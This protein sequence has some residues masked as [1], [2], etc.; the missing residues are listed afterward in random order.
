MD[1]I[2]VFTIGHSNVPAEHILELLRQY[3]IEVLVDVRSMPYSRH[4]PQFNR[5]TFQ[6]FLEA[7]GIRYVYEGRDLGGRPDDPDCYDGNQV[8]YSRIAMK[9]WYQE[10]IERLIEMARHHRVAIMCSEEDPLHC[11]R[12]NLIAQTLLERG[13]AVW[14]IRGDGRIEES[15]LNVPQ[16]QQL[17]LL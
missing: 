2:T 3:G 11:H 12:H 5:E 1:E 17:A 14:H 13:V 16:A 6:R 7:S 9:P 10:G 15:R 8:Q 4:N